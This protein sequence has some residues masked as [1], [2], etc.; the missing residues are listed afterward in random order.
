MGMLSWQ[1]PQLEI[2]DIGFIQSVDEVFQA[3]WVG[4]RYWEPKG[5]FRS[6]NLNFNQWTGWNFDGQST[7]S[8]GNVNLHTQFTNYWAISMGINRQGESKSASSLRGGPILRLPGSTSS[9]YN[10]SSDQRKDFIAG[11]GGYT[12]FGDLDYSFNQD[13]YLN[14]SYRPIRSLMVRVSPGYSHQKN[15]MQYVS[16]PE[17]GNDKRYVRGTIDRDTWYMSLRVEYSVSPNLSIQYY[18]RP[19]LSSGEFTDY[20]YI[21][22]PKADNYNDRFITFEPGQ[23]TYNVD[24]K[25]FSVDENRDGTIDYTFSDRNFN[26][27]DLQSTMVLRWEFKPGSTFFAVWTHGKNSWENTHSASLS[28][29]V[30]NLFSSVPHNIFLIKFSYRFN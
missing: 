13:V 20:K 1:T 8:G 18:G 28:D 29:D 14:L 10:I 21:T 30:D 5:I 26:Y 24:D 2:N 23:L 19:Y 22:N 27:L 17:F 3:F 11:A 16:N 25:G 7:Y 12:Q 6:V 9:W 15:E 4:L